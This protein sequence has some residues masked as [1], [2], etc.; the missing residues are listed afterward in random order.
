M[1]KQTVVYPDME[2]YSVMNRED[3]SYNINESQSNTLGEKTR[4]ERLHTT[5][6]HLY[7]LE[8]ANYS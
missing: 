2:C 4:Y 7:K 1:D 8:K 5:W 3:Y 6:L